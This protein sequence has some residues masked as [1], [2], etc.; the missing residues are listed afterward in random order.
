MNIIEFH[1][2]D[3][4]NP[5]DLYS[6]PCRYFF[7]D[8]KTTKV[9]IDNVRKTTWN[10]LDTLIVGG[11]GLIGNENFEKLMDRI[12]N[13]PD[14]QLLVDVIETKLKNISVENKELIQKW[15]EFVQRYT[16]NTISQLDKTIG[17]RILWGAGHNSR[18]KVEDSYFINYPSY[19]NRFHLVGVRDW[20]EDYRWVPCASCM[21]PAFDK[22][23]EI[24]NE[25]VWFEHKKKLIDGR[26]LDLLPA[27]RM[28]N[29]GQNMDQ[30]IE[31]LGSGETV[32]TNSYHGVY[33]ATLLGRKVVC[34]PWGTK[35]N[36]FKHPPTMATDKDW[37]DK[38]EEA[39]S[40]PNALKEC[41]NA[42]KEFYEDVIN[43]MNPT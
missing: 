32:V 20:V 3:Q 16:L 1:R 31:F 42:N 7:P 14:E 9:D 19:L 18:D 27:P 11:G 21:H 22:E 23:Y 38:I 13:H 12:T 17:P 24:K 39:E 37:I 29:T 35:F 26:S 40:Y 28:L 33:W 4:N 5:G 43:L 6:N 30:I 8:V 36:M 2:I 10:Q 41:R 34:V 25:F 15:K